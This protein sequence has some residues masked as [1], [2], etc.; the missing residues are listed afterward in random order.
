MIKNALYGLACH[1]SLC[2]WFELA[3]LGDSPASHT[4]FIARYVTAWSNSPRPR[5]PLLLLTGS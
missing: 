4:E 1:L 3:L 5:L 2:M